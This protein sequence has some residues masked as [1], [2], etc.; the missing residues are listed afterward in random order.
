M[1]AEK[2][3]RPRYQ[4]HD[5]S[6]GKTIFLKNV[7]FS[8]KNEELKKRMEMFGPVYYALVCIDS[9]TEFSRGTAFVKFKVNIRNRHFIIYL[10]KYF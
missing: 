4:S 1:N 2:E 6:E 9:L 5:V 7:P 8:V 3:K 10:Y